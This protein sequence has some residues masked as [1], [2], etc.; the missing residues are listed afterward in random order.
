MGEEDTRK[1]C[2]RYGFADLRKHERRY[3]DEIFVRLLN[4][5]I[6]EGWRMVVGMIESPAKL[7][8]IDEILDP[9]LADEASFCC[10]ED[11]I[12]NV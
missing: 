4:A 10:L 2:R 7:D 9:N 11:E 3:D 12:Q 8:R 6:G 5:K 1:L